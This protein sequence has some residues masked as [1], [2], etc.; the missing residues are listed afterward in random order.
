MPLL[1]MESEAQK[2]GRRMTSSTT[3]QGIRKELPKDS[4]TIKYLLPE[5]IPFLIV[6]YDVEGK[7]KRAM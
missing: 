5:G 1:W 2:A 6:Y 4:L 7:R 3:K